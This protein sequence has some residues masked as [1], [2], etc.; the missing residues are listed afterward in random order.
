MLA[1]GGALLFAARVTVGQEAVLAAL[2]C[3]RV[4]RS[5]LGVAA[6]LVAPAPKGYIVIEARNEADA[7][8]ALAG[9]PHVKGLLRRPMAME[10]LRDLLAVKVAEVVIEK[11][12]LV[13]VTSGPF[14]GAQAKVVRVDKEK[15]DATIEFLE[16]V[17][18]IP[19]TLKLEAI[20]PIPK[21]TA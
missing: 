5:G 7:R 21:T 11:G 16:M 10:E 6:L 19:V 18:A 12:D 1:S 14:K 15:G 20:K 2:I 4:K 17:V 3:E 13:E 9:L 8:A